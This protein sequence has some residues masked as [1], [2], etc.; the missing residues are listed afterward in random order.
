M[1][2]VTEREEELELNVVP[3]ETEKF[4]FPGESAFVSF[5]VSRR[6]SLL[7]VLFSSSRESTTGSS[8]PLLYHIT[9][10]PLLSEL[11]PTLKLFNPFTDLIHDTF[12]VEPVPFDLSPLPLL[13]LLRMNAP[14]LEFSS[15]SK[16]G[17]ASKH[18]IHMIQLDEGGDLAVGD[19][20]MEKFECVPLYL[21]FWV[22]R[23]RI[24]EEE[25][26][27]MIEDSR[28]KVS[29]STLRAI[30]SLPSLGS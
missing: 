4:F 5:R 17:V 26:L 20:E 21:P 27:V 12:P 13:D 2:V 18:R 29:P 25:V 15:T 6:V 11:P 30:L 10:T 3:I 8:S 1:G 22:A 19:I 24:E 28:E 7:L 14:S 16:T 9:C 23:Y